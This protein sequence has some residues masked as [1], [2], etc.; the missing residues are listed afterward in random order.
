MNL[1]FRV[2]DKKRNEW[3]GQSNDSVLVLKDFTLFG[4]CMYFCPPS[5]G[6]LQYL[7]TD[8][9]T[10]VNDL[11]DIKIYSNDVCQVHFP[12]EHRWDTGLVTFKDGA[13]YVGSHLL[14]DVKDRCE[15]IGNIYES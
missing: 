7:E 3:Y 12:E 15:V 13:F 11:R 8:M 9:Y 4:E 10:G 6:D 5:I 14:A 1:L 2:W